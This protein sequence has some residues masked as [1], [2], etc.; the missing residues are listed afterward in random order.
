MHTKRRKDI[1]K[2]FKKLIALS[3]VLMTVFALMIPAFAGAEPINTTTRILED[4][5]KLVYNEH[6]LQPDDPKLGRLSVRYEN[7]VQYVEDYK[8]LEYE[9]WVDD[10]NCIYQKDNVN[11][12]VRVYMCT[13]MLIDEYRF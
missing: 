12:I 3:L 4:G 2:V 5:T 10:D 6:L 8:L 11:R 7:G 9:E 1:R 13:G